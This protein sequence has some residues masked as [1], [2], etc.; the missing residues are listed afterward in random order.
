MKEKNNVSKQIQD[1][2]SLEN[3]INLSNIFF[4]PN[5]YILYDTKTLLSRQYKLGMFNRMDTVVRYLA[6]EE[7]CGKE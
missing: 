7:Y 6:I 5:M 1:S 3:V 2:S 4:D